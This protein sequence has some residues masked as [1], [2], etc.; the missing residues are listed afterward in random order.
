MGED[1]PQR[2]QSTQLTPRQGGCVPIS[3]VNILPTLLSFQARFRLQ[4]GEERSFRLRG[5]SG[6]FDLN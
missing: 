1:H 3:R 2:A 5:G 6:P 4:L